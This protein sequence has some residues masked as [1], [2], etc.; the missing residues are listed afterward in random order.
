MINNRNGIMSCI[1]YSNSLHQILERTMKFQRRRCNLFVR[2][3]YSYLADHFTKIDR[4]K[5]T[6]TC[7]MLYRLTITDSKLF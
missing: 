3:L 6:N 1:D 4:I 7:F 5:E 2:R